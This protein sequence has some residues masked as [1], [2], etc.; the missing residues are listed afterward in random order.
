MDSKIGSR[1][2]VEDWRKRVVETTTTPT[3]IT[4]PLTASSLHVKH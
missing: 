3:T 1:V 2:E 4:P